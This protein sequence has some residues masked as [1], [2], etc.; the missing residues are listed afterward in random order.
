MPFTFVS[1]RLGVTLDPETVS[2]LSHAFATAILAAPPVP[3][4]G[5]MEAVQAAAARVPIAVISDTGISPASSLRTLLDRNGFTPYFKA[6]TFSDE[7]G[8]SKPQAPMFHTTAKAL[9]VPAS[10]FL[11]IGDLEPTDIAGVQAQ[12][13]QAALFTAVNPRFKATTK[14]EYILDSWAQFVEM[15]PDILS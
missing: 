5:A 7:V 10:E 4:D 2:G 15:L 13:G 11:H 8:V 12:G 14:A 9:G 6:L 3:I 1:E